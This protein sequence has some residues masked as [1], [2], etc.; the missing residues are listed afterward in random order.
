MRG[1][2]PATLL[3]AL[4]GCSGTGSTPP[5]PPPPAFDG[6][7]FAAH[8][9][10]SNPWNPVM[11]DSRGGERLMPVEP[12]LSI[13]DGTEAD[14]RRRI[15]TRYDVSRDGKYLYVPISTSILRFE[16]PEGGSPEVLAHAPIPQHLQVSPS[17]DWL[18]F[19]EVVGTRHFLMRSDGSG[20]ARNI[21]TPPV[22]AGLSYSPPVWVT[23]GHMMVIVQ[24]INGAPY[25][26]TDYKVLELKA[27]DWI[28]TE[29]EPLNG[30]QLVIIGGDLVAS[31]D[32]SR[33]YVRVRDFEADPDSIPIVEY[34]IGQYTGQVRFKV[35]RGAGGRMVVSPD[36]RMLALLEDGNVVVREIE[37]GRVITRLIS[38]GLA[39]PWPMAWVAREYE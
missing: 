8:I 28:A 36:G 39:E 25:Y 7:I 32:G 26:G 35:G 18:V 10:G 13:W 17:G 3:A 38:G 1:R 31:P 5:G 24:Q 22:A 16:L 19:R 11:L 14:W 29:Y 15:G 9:V 30:V 37:T 34:P 12:I 2:L 6:T 20:E 4:A 27:P 23:D 33:L 21:F